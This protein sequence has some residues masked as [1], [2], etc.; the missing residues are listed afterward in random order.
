MGKRLGIIIGINNY[1]DT[2]FQPLKFA[3]ND[4]R[5][6]AQW[7]VN[8]R[9][10]NW[11]PSNV[12]LLLGD[13]AT[14]KLA[15]SLIAQSSLNMVDHDD[16]IFIYFAGQAF[17]DETNEE[18]YLAFVDTLMSQ[19]AK[20][21]SILSLFNQTILPSS[22][23]QIVLVVDSF[24]TGSVWNKR[25]TSQFDFKPLLGATLQHSLNQAQGRL[26]YCSCRGNEHA[27]EVGE[28]SIGKLLYHMI[29]GLSNQADSD[30]GQV[31]LQNLHALLLS[32][33]N[34][35][36]QPQVFGQDHRPIVLVGEMPAFGN[37]QESI[38]VSPLSSSVQYSN[39][40]S[41]LMSNKGTEHY[42]E[43]SISIAHAQKSTATLGQSSIEILEQNRRKQCVKMLNQ[44]QQQVQMQN[45]PA[46]LN[47]IENILQIAPDFVDALIV[48][49]Q[50][51]GTNGY[52]QD[53]LAA[54]NQ[55]LHVD[56]DNA[57]GWSIYATL[58]ANLG[59]LHE[60]SSAIDRSLAL[61]PN[62]PEALALRDAIF[63]NLARSSFPEQDFRFQSTSTSASKQGGVKSFFISAIIQIFALLAGMIGAS[64][65]LIRPQLPIIIAFF[66]E[67]IAL[68]ILCVNAAI[69]TY[70]YGIKRF[71]LILAISL[72]TLGILGA[73]Y[74]FGYHWLINRVIALPPLIV[75][76]L[77]LGF[78]LVT[79]A[80]LPLL[81]AV[82]G[83][84]SG[85]IIGTRRKRK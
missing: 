23:A 68:A 24:Q 10:G 85:V 57:L 72:I 18:G 2:A 58:L 54:A 79:A 25:K 81:L 52:F 62:N 69:G 3:E 74:R 40:A 29:L 65:R 15:R 48:K 53:A 42:A 70:V 56:P 14:S 73:L 11:N 60:A 33:L 30:A 78:W 44:A 46:A 63:S 4:A 26:L 37:R 8:S 43:S 50:L 28:K 32:S 61:N 77:F 16:L 9:G 13:Q 83:L 59:Q 27:S 7:L 76:V 1:Q 34:K 17:V 66:L 84:L 80:I 35:Q 71:L 67:S 20:T 47:I 82:G 38:S 22:A 6:L 39:Q 31:T 12:Q 36:H 64:S 19:P 55:I 75:P 21:Q 49:A 5:A 41:Q 45:I 51:L